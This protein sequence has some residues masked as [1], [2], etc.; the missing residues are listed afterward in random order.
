MATQDTTMKSY[1]TLQSAIK[2]VVDAH[3]KIS[4]RYE[5]TYRTV[6]PEKAN[7][8]FSK[9]IQQQ[10]ENMNIIC[11]S[12]HDIL[13]QAGMPNDIAFEISRFTKTVLESA[14]SSEQFANYATLLQENEEMNRRIEELKKMF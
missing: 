14:E 7:L 12:L 11:S 3:Y 4:D 6:S 2:K 8:F 13:F 1:E 9:T 5:I 10:E